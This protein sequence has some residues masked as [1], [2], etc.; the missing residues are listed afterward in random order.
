MF[1]VLVSLS[2]VDF[3]CGTDVAGLLSVTE[4]FVSLTRADD[5]DVVFSAFKSYQTMTS[6]QCHPQ[7]MCYKLYPT[8]V[9]YKYLKLNEEE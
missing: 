2:F 6:T 5:R 9:G 1:T 4:I 8:Q 7:S 3:D